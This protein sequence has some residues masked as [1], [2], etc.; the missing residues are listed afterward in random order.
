MG[1]V[2]E[3][4]RKQAADLGATIVMLELLDGN[5]DKLHALG[6]V[7]Q[8][9]YPDGRTVS[10]DKSDGLHIRISGMKIVTG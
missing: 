5:G 4:L 10:L 1:D 6:F 3:G 2:M 8:A 9:E 7:T